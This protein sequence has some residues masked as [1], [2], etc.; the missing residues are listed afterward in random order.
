MESQ[1]WSFN[2][3]VLLKKTHRNSS[4]LVWTLV[5]A[6]LFATGW[7]FLAPLPETIAVKGKLQPTTPVLDIEAPLPGVVSSVEVHEGQFVQQGDVLLR[8]D[9]KEIKARL[10]AAIANRDSLIQ[11]VAINKVLIGEL[12]PDTLTRNQQ[13]LLQNRQRQEAQTLAADASARERNRLKID[14]L[15]KTVLQTELIADRY[16]KL[17]KNGAAS[18]LQVLEMQAR[19]DRARTDL[20]TE[21]REQERL[22]ASIEAGTSSREAQRRREIEDSLQRIADYNRDIRTNQ[23]QLRNAVV[24]APKEGYIFNLAVASGSLVERNESRPLLKLVPKGDLQAKVYIPNNAI[25]FVKSNQPV[26]ISLNSFRASDYAFL[27]A[28]IKSIGSDALTPEEQQ[29]VLGRGAEG[30]YFPAILELKNQNLTVGEQQIVLQPGMSLT[31]D[32]HLRDRRFIS[33][34]TDLLEDKRRSLERLR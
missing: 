19:V 20:S 10:D 16:S 1:S 18:E 2:Q 30:L 12:A 3:P 6:T 4:V 32:I 33:A 5:G 23:S 24:K 25:G 26:N 21:L 15:R 31:A 22:V 28:T 9:Q 14:G 17:L 34:I 29:R 7:A 11:K 8:F 13:K 27:P